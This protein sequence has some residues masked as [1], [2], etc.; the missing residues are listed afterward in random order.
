MSNE[1]DAH[2]WEVE[3]PPVVLFDRRK[4][5]DRRTEWRGGRRDSDWVNRPPGAFAK[6]EKLQRGYWRR[7]FSMT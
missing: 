5:P 6:L 3:T 4:R 1:F 7:L 2:E